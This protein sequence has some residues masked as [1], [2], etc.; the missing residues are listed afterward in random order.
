[1]AANRHRHPHKSQYS[2]QEQCSAGQGNCARG[3]RGRARERDSTSEQELPVVSAD[4][5][6]S[7]PQ[8]GRDTQ[9]RCHPSAGRSSCHAPSGTAHSLCK[10][11]LGCTYADDRASSSV[12]HPAAG[13]R[14][15]ANRYTGTAA[16]AAAGRTAAAA[17]RR[18]RQ[19]GAL[20]HSAPGCARRGRA[21]ASGGLACACPPAFLGPA[22]RRGAARLY[23]KKRAG[24]DE[25]R[26]GSG[27][28]GGGRQRA[29]RGC[30]G[31]WAS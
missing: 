23:F 30:S 8:S 9:L 5:G 19:A 24:N 12:D 13:R 18:Q 22:A 16:A 17:A 21:V 1:M 7:P 25:E 11:Q 20:D 14:R 27:E 31:Q 28:S 3:R 4:C 2:A 29:R 26:M 10:P 6:Q 15:P